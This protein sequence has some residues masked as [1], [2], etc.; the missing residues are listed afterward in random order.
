MKVYQIVWL[1][2]CGVLGVVGASAAFAR[3]ASAM[4][5]LFALA[6]I[7]VGVVALL[8]LGP[9]YTDSM[10]GEMWRMVGTHSLGSGVAAVAVVGFDAMLG[11][12][13]LVLL[14]A[15]VA[16]S[17]PYVIRRYRRWLRFLLT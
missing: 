6:T 9:D 13:G 17:S 16:F 1:T 11:G 3:S 4:L 10:P 8:R 14:L 7:G 15:V 5:V 12:R 2:L